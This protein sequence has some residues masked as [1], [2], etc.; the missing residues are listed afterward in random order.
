MQAEGQGRSA[1]GQTKAAS[2]LRVETFLSRTSLP[3]SNLTLTSHNKVFG[4]AQERL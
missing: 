3:P 2:P 4:S 1:E